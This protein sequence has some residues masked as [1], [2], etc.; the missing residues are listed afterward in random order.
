MRNRENLYLRH[1]LDLLPERVIG[2]PVGRD[3]AAAVGLAALLGKKEG[4]DASFALLPAD[5]VIQDAEGFQATLET[6]F[7]A[8]EA[9]DQL[10]T[11]ESSP[12]F[13]PPDMDIWNR[14]WPDMNMQAVRWRQS[15]VLWRNQ[16]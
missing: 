6:A 3:T 2:E 4:E 7:E 5:H 13:H 12:P 11:V 10:V 8:A 15:A 16:I 14:R 9:E 1:V